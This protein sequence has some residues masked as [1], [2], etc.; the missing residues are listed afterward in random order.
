MGRVGRDGSS[1]SS[2][3]GSAS[4]PCLFI[5][6]FLFQP[7]TAC[8]PVSFSFSAA[9]SCCWVQGAGK[10]QAAAGQGRRQVSMPHCQPN[11]P[12]KCPASQPA[13]HCRQPASPHATVPMNARSFLLLEG[14]GEGGK[15][16]EGRDPVCMK[17]KM[18][19]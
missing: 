12:A 17:P 6:L 5:F 4:I 10:V 7:P 14:E 15:G 19:V 11:A 18:R 1:C 9:K 3:A 13:S 8:L 16:R 2:K